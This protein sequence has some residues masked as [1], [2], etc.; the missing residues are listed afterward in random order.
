MT[1]AKKTTDIASDMPLDAYLTVV[2]GPTLTQIQD[3][4]HQLKEDVDSL[5]GHHPSGWSS[6][7]TDELAENIAGKIVSKTSAPQVTQAEQKK[8]DQKSANSLL[9]AAKEGV[10]KEITPMVQSFGSV[11]TRLE[12]AISSLENLSN[13]FDEYIKTNQAMTVS[14]IQRYLHQVLPAVTALAAF[15]ISWGVYHNS[16]HYWGERFYKLANDPMQTEQMVLDVRSEA[17]EAVKNEF[18]KGRKTSTKSYVKYAESRLKQYK[19][20]MKKAEQERKR[21]AKKRRN[22]KHGE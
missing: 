3:D 13:K 11:K 14:R 6:S 18:E 9:N 17:F 8:D 12:T 20:A 21:Q 5:K 10:R 22:A 19:K 15:L 4:L 16:Y 2:V 1:M 7:E